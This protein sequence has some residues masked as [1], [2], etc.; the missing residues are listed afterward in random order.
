MM[1]TPRRAQELTA[2]SG[3]EGAGRG[4][5]DRREGEQAGRLASELAG[6]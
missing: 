2:Y 3:G 5:D 1:N 6:R 4:A